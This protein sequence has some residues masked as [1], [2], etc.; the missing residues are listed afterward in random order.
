[1]EGRDTFCG[2]EMRIK[3]FGVPLVYCKEI[4]KSLFGDKIKVKQGYINNLSLKKNFREKKEISFFNLKHKENLKK[5]K[6][7][8]RQ[9]KNLSFGNFCGKVDLSFF[10]Q[11]FKGSSVKIG[12]EIGSKILLI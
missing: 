4:I 9:F 6:K 3:G 11:N 2:F 10:V 8:S 1:M 12:I 7:F 5:S